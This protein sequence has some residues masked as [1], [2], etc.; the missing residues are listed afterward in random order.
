MCVCVC[1]QGER[2]VLKGRWE[3]QVEEWVGEMWERGRAKVDGDESVW[4]M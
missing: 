1:E 2:G 3:G 4:R